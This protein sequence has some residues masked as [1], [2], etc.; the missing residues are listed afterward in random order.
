VTLG[1]SGVSGSPYGDGNAARKIIEVIA[2]RSESRT[3]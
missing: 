1:K 2:Q 3:H